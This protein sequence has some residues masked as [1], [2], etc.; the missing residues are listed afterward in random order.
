MQTQPHPN[1]AEPP[2]VLPPADNLTLARALSR[3]LDGVER[4]RAA[5]A[6]KAMEKS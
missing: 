2:V 1:T 4:N 5:Q 6:A 3:A